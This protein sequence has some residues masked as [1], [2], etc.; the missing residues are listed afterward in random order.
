MVAQLAFGGDDQGDDGS[1]GYQ[2]DEGD[3]L[4]D[5]REYDDVEDDEA[6]SRFALCVSSG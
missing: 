1:D 3:D 6:P 5:A 4:Y 2:N